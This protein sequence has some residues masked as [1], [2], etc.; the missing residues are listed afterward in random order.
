[1]QIRYLS[2]VVKLQTFDVDFKITFLIMCGAF[3]ITM[4][5]HYLLFLQNCNVVHEAKLQKL[6]AEVRDKLF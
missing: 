5:E 6:C 1:M 2:C 3:L 4:H